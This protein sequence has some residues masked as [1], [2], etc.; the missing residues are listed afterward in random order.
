MPTYKKNPA[1]DEIRLPGLGRVTTDEAI[2][3]DQWGRFAKMSAKL[4]IE[5][6]DAPTPPPMEAT[7]RPSK[8]VL[9]E[10]TQTKPALESTPVKE[11][12]PLLTEDDPAV[13]STSTSAGPSEQK[14]ESRNRPSARK[15]R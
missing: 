14:E 9:T 11:V 13:K 5:V 7:P 10:P 12:A 4:L 6:P 1:Y 8:P 2:E 15:P 3:G